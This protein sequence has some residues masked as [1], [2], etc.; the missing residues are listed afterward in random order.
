MKTI[1]LLLSALVALFA[2]LI[3]AGAVVTEKGQ[4][5]EAG[6]APIIIVQVCHK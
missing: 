3:I 6:F 1:I 4:C 5:T 2:L